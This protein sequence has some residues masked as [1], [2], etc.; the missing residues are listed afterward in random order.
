MKIAALF[1]LSLTIAVGIAAQD[2]APVIEHDPSECFEVGSF[3][4]LCA[5]VTTDGSLGQ[6]RAY[7][8]ASRTTKWYYVE[9]TEDEGELCSALPSPLPE[10][11]G[12]EYY[13]EV[14]DEEFQPAITPTAEAQVVSDGSCGMPVYETAGVVSVFSLATSLLEVPAGFAASSVATAGGAS[15]A[16]AAG[17]AAGG[18]GGGGLSGVTIGAI[19]AGAGAAA[20]AGV[21]VAGSSVNT[22]TTTS[23]PPATTRS[24]TASLLGISPPSGSIITARQG[25]VAVSL[26]VA[27]T[28]NYSGNFWV[29]S[30]TGMR[31]GP[32]E[33]CLSEPGF[34]DIPISLAVG[35]SSTADVELQVTSICAFPFTAAWGRIHTPACSLSVTRS[36]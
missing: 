35:E 13:I 8:R 14:V 10:T 5:D 20:A 23:V 7:F 15:G 36:P 28:P 34:P 3:P 27:I 21:A 30:C 2:T 31:G 11:P 18:S 29:H 33:C 6:A 17:G 26:R 32:N 24:C 25:E 19:A 22:T 16:G 9:L 4:R 12:V 1:A